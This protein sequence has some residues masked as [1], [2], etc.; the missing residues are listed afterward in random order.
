MVGSLISEVVESLDLHKT[1]VTVGLDFQ[2]GIAGAR[3]S[4]AQRQKLAVARA[5]LK[6][7]DL[8][9][10]NEATAP[11]DSASQAKV[12]SNVL[13]ASEGRG[14]IWVLNRLQEAQKF[15][16]IVVMREGRIVEQGSYDELI[17]NGGVFCDLLEVE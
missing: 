6:R 4:T 3:L 13:Q 5:L 2:A 10:I 14:V 9:I 11:L 12:L 8:L 7:S 1:V 15:H 16:H 17:Q